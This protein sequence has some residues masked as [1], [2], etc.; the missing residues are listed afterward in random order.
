MNIQAAI[1][2]EISKVV[3]LCR[4]HLEA[5]DFITEPIY[6]SPDINSHLSGVKISF[7]MEGQHYGFIYN[8]NDFNFNDCRIAEH[9]ANSLIAEIKIQNKKLMAAK[10]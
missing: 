4:I 9:V 7:Y 3:N 1:M 2:M 5:I 8:Y 10:F 6:N